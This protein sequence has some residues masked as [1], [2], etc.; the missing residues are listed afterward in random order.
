MCDERERLIGY[1]YDECDPAERRVIE[2]HL[3]DCGTCRAEIGGL[4]GVRQDLLAWDVPPHEAV[5]RPLVPAPVVPW[6]RQVPAWA[7]A[8]AA[9]VMF[10]VGAAG[11]VVTHALV[12]HDRATVV[13]ATPTQTIPAGVTAGQLTEVEQRMVQMM[14]DELSKRE[15]AVRGGPTPQVVPA[16]FGAALTP[17]RVN[18]LIGASEQRQWETMRD[19]QND[20]LKQI[21]SLKREVSGLKNEVVLMQSGGGR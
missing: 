10:L 11:G 13:T 7:M 19:V 1:V 18:E 8:A 9:G 15:V 3:E 4:R 2:E 5:W 16:S 20:F 17:V 21:S 14:R 6:Y 12:P